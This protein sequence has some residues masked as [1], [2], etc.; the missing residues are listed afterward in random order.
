MGAL[1]LS[2]QNAAPAQTPLSKNFLFQYDT[3]APAFARRTGLTSI[4]A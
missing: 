2:P 1:S 3:G 4:F